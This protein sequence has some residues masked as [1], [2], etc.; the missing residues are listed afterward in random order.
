MKY[1]IANKKYNQNILVLVTNGKLK[2]YIQ[3]NNNNKV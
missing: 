2:I 1:N 3:K